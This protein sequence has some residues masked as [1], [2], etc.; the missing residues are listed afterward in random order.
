MID[1]YCKYYNINAINKN[2]ICDFYEYVNGN[3]MHNTKIPDDY[4]EWSTFSI[5]QMENMDKENKLLIDFCDHPIGIFYQK[6]LL[7][8]NDNDAKNNSNLS[9]ESL[10]SLETLKK[11]IEAVDN[12]DNMISLAIMLS[13]MTKIGLT[14]FFTLDAVEDSEDSK[15]VKLSMWT[16]SLSM[17]EIEYYHNDELKYYR[18]MFK[19][20]IIECFELIKKYFDKMNDTYSISNNI[21]IIEKML[22]CIQKPKI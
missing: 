16:A 1:A 7:I 21:F 20:H 9:T 15:Y 13:A 22:S 11:Y 14:P 3:W 18:K 6:L 17:P 10:K 2:P 5:A 19:K 12:I 8:N 4:S